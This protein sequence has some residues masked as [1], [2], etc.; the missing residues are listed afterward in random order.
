[1]ISD[2]NGSHPSKDHGIP[3]ATMARR[4]VAKLQTC[5]I[6]NQGPVTTVSSPVS[7]R[8]GFRD[9]IV[10]PVSHATRRE[11]P[12]ASASDVGQR[13]EIESNH[14][15]NIRPGATRSRTSTGAPR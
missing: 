9:L 13:Q 11:G 1:M 10:E 4:R 15:S 5:D 8:D 6:L 2:K 12:G 3:V 7:K 14:L